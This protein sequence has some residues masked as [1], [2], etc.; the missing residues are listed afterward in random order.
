MTTAFLSSIVD[1]P[2]APP[3]GLGERYRRI[4]AVTESPADREPTLFEW[5]GGF[6][7]LTA[8]TRIFYGRHV[9]EDPLLAPLFANMKPDHPERVA[10]WLGEVFGGPPAYSE[11]YGGYPRMVS[12]HIGKALT[13]EK[14]ARWVQL[15][16]LSAQRHTVLELAML[17]AMSCA[18]VRFWIQR[19]NRHGPA[20][21]YDDPRSGRPRKA[22]PHVQETLV[23]MLQDDPRHAGYL[24]TFWTVAMLGLALVHTVAVQLSASARRLALHELGLRWG[25]PRRSSAR[26]QILA[27]TRMVSRLTAAS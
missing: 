22:N 5:A 18:T 19:F 27:K 1:R 7:A 15:I 6:P 24:A 4:R 11:Q 12:Q 17:F 20:G 8:M 23:A 25:R 13:E 26:A 10:A 16:L 14:R 3:A 21:L 9:P 2:Q